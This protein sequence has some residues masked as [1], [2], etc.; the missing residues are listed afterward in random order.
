[1]LLSLFISIKPFCVFLLIYWPWIG[2][3]ST[4]GRVIIRA[5]HRLGD[6]G[7]SKS[8]DSAATPVH[9]KSEKSDDRGKS[10]PAKPTR[11]EVTLHVQRVQESDWLEAS[12]SAG[13]QPGRTG[14]DGDK[15]APPPPFIFNPLTSPSFSDGQ[16]K[17]P[18]A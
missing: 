3:L 18:F 9:D 10:T 14:E 17:Y 11:L 7:A 2:A 4:M 6:S 12:Q 15:P 8:M 13:D 1:M 5:Q 16:A